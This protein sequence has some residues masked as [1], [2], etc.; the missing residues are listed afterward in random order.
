MGIA[1]W[2]SPCLMPPFGDA[3]VFWCSLLWILVFFE[4]NTKRILGVFGHPRSTWCGLL[5]G[6][7]ITGEELMVG[8][9]GVIR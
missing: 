7:A 5:E 2:Y 4:M 8:I 9:T 3:A 1:G 6:L